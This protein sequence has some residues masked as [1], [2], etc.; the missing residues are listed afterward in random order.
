[1]KL[2]AEDRL[3]SVF[4]SMFTPM[5]ASRRDNCLYVSPCC[6]GLVIRA[7]H[8]QR[9][10]P[11]SPDAVGFRAAEP[12]SSCPVSLCAGPLFPY[13]WEGI[14]SPLSPDLHV[15]ELFKRERR[16]ARTGPKTKVQAWIAEGGPGHGRGLQA[17][18]RR[19]VLRSRAGA[20][21]CGA[22]NRSGSTTSFR[23]SIPP[24]PR[25]GVS[26]PSPTSGAVPL[27]RDITLDAARQLGCAIRTTRH[28]GAGSHDRG[29]PCHT[30]P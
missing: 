23:T 10:P 3:F 20:A 13:F 6:R 26:P 21:G 1:V 22:T 25:P 9:H 7:A 2:A 27:D 11:E 19:H 28:Q 24:L 30:N 5:S 14:K 16:M 8:S 29:F 15:P 18:A 17:V 4:G 12:W